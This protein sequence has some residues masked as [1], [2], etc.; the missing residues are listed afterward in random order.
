MAAAVAVVV[1]AAAAVV[2]V[3]AAA[4]VVVVVAAAALEVQSGSTL[5]SILGKQTF[6]M[7]LLQQISFNKRWRESECVRAC[8]RAYV[9]ERGIWF[10]FHLIISLSWYPLYIYIQF[11]LYVSPCLHIS[12]KTTLPLSFSIISFS[13][14]FSLCHSYIFLEL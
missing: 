5:A 11:C 8:V 4:V 13:L 9:R 6:S 2:V 7:K 3:A 14:P 1:V 12:S 10:S